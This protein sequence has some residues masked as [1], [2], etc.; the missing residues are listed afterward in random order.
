MNPKWN[1]LNGGGHLKIPFLSHINF[2]KVWPSERR[3]PWMFESKNLQDKFKNL[4]S[5]INSDLSL[6]HKEIKINLHDDKKRKQ[7][8][9]FQN[10]CFLK[11]FVF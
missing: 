2:Y 9:S 6:I 4:S 3:I 11:T 7:D 5:K 8:D 1:L 10:D